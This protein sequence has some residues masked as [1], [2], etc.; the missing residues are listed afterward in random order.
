MHASEV[1]HH[2]Y[3]LKSEKIEDSGHV[4][5]NS[6]AVFTN[7]QSCGNGRLDFSS[8][9]MSVLQLLGSWEEI[10]TARVVSWFWHSQDG[11]LKILVFCWVSSIF[12]KESFSKMPRINSFSEANNLRVSNSLCSSSF[13]L[14]APRTDSVSLTKP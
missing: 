1:T 3:Q 10:G 6:L 11:S 14:R 8:Y 9:S 2:L 13:C 5:A 12:L 7:T 4:P